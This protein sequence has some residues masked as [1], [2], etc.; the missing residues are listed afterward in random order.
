MPRVGPLSCQEAQENAAIFT[1]GGAEAA[2]GVRVNR[3]D[4]R[5]AERSR[6]APAP[7]RDGV[8]TREAERQ[9][10]HEV[11]ARIVPGRSERLADE[12]NASHERSAG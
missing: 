3:L 11:L 5:A 8:V 4:A 12:K 6:V 9:I 10:A 1:Q 7:E 2:A